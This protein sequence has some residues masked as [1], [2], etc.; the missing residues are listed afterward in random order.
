MIE[1][2]LD[3]SDRI[4]TALKAF[5]RK[6]QRAGILKELREKRH[7]EKPSDARKRKAA[8]ARRRARKRT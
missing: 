2:L 5:K 4:E 8:A 1:V 3:D 7:Y 6:V